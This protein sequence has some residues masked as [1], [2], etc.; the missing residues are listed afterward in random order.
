M[1]LLQTGY[2]LPVSIGNLMID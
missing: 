2:L 1:S